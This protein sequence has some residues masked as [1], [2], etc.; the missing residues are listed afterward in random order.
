MEGPNDSKAII[1]SN[2]AIIEQMYA[3]LAD[4]KPEGFLSCLAEDVRWTII[5][6][7]R[8]SKT[9][10]GKAQLVAGLLEPFMAE[11]DGHPTITPKR[12]IAEGEFVAMQSEGLART[13]HGKD[14]NNTYCHV[15]RIRDGLV[16]EVTEYLDTELIT[17][18]FRP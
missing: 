18:A 8:F 17:H 4:H 12:L 13:V 14:Y 3:A 15:F 2:K 10:D 5:G 11:L 16:S 9:Y 6:T 1:E 7:T